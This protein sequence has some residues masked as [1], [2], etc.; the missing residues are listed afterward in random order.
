MASSIRPVTIRFPAL[1][2]AWDGALVTLSQVR[3][4]RILVT[5]CTPDGLVRPEGLSGE[6][7]VSPEQVSDLARA[8][9]EFWRRNP[10]LLTQARARPL[11]VV[12]HAP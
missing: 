9:A 8:T 10:G 4:D 6:F 1:S 5:E 7:T 12:Q 3:P 2:V 11:F